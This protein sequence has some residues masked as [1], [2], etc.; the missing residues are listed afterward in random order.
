[1]VLYILIF[2]FLEGDGSTKDSGQRG[3]GGHSPN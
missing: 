2:G 1:M 3:G